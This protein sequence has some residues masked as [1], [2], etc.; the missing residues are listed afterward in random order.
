MLRAMAWKKPS[1]TLVETFDAVVP[2]APA[3]RRQMFGYPAAFVN[4]NLFMSLFEESLVLRLDDGPRG[5]LLAGGATQF[6]PMKGRPMKEYVVAPAAL[7]ADRAA[8]KKWA[9]KAF[10]YG[11]SLPPKAKKPAKRAAAKKKPAR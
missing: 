3:E 5:A 2:G 6:E 7:V 4:G 1:Q 8:L 11:K 10:A 9:D